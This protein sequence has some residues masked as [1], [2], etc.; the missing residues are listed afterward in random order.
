MFSFG[1]AP[2]L[3]KPLTHH[4]VNFQTPLHYVA[5]LGN[6][7]VARVLLKCEGIKIEV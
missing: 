2:Q 7:V 4:F 3:L 1:E 6:I 5:K